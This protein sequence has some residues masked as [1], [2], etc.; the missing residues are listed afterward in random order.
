MKTIVKT[1]AVLG[2]VGILALAAMTPSEA[3]PRWG[4]G[5][6]AAGF[7]AGAFIGAAAANANAYYYGDPYY[8]YGYDPGYY[9]GGPVVVAPTYGYDAYGYA[10]GYYGP[11]YYPRND[12]YPTRNR[13]LEGRDY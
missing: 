8:A 7:A 2:V 11:R 6:A 12:Q 10:P 9:Y 5:A 4:W 1:G 13:V 3:R